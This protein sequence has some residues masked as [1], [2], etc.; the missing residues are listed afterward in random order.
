MSVDVFDPIDLTRAR[1]WLDGPVEAGDADDVVAFRRKAWV[2]AE[3][4]SAWVKL[5]FGPYVAKLRRVCPGR[6]DQVTLQLDGAAVHCDWPLVRQLREI[7]VDVLIL[8]PGSTPVLQ[9]CDQRFGEVKTAARAKYRRD[10]DKPLPAGGRLARGAR[11][12]LIACQ[13]RLLGLGCGGAEARR[14]RMLLLN[15]LLSSVDGRS[16][17]VRSVY[18]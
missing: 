13:A 14:V 1:R 8:C 16:F 18:R 15:G 17:F 9:P 3:L 12:T 7:N 6:Y 4:W 10:V 2:S 11:A 5:I